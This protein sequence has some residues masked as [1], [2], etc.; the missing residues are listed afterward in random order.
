MWNINNKLKIIFRKH[1]IIN[2]LGNQLR[3]LWMI[4]HPII[5]MIECSA[6]I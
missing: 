4:S 5:F 3:F 6:V 1:P 2:P